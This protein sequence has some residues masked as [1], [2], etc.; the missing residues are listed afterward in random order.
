MLSRGGNESAYALWSVAV[1]LEKLV[2]FVQHN[3]LLCPYLLSEVVRTYSD[4]HWHV[5]PFVL[6]W[7]EIKKKK[8]KGELVC[9]SVHVREKE[10][11]TRGTLK[12]RKKRKKICVCPGL[13]SWA[14]LQRHCLTISEQKKKVDGTNWPTSL[15]WSK[16]NFISLY[17][18]FDNLE[19]WTLLFLCL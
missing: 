5:C 19:H 10:R 11:N 8:R 7:W 12:I 18:A 9:V 3:R 2:L 6:C 14:S 1:L 15:K 16:D 4:W 17:K 13:I